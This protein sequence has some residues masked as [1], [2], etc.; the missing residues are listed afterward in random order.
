MKGKFILTTII[1]FSTSLTYGQTERVLLSELS[2]KSIFGT[3]KKDSLHIYSLLGTG[4]FKTPCSENSD[5]LITEWLEKHPDARVIPISSF[6]PLFSDKNKEN[7]LMT[8]CWLVDKNDTLNNHLVRNGCFPGGTM[9][10]PQTKEEMSKEER[11]F[12]RKNNIEF[13][14]VQIHI[15][16]KEYETFIKQIINAQK[17]AEENKLGVWKKT[18]DQK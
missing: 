16:K 12:H 14:K 3:S 18:N 1:I 4:F 7:S 13:Q 2:F 10:R 17:Y 9:M 8:Y 11:K 15:E 5:S 6:G